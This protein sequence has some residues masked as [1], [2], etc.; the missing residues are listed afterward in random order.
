[1]GENKNTKLVRIQEHKKKFNI[2]GNILSP[3]PIIL[4]IY[5][6]GL[7]VIQYLFFYDWNVK[8]LRTAAIIEIAF[9][10]FN[11]LY[12]GTAKKKKTFETYLI[13]LTI[14]KTIVIALSILGSDLSKII[15]NKTGVANNDLDELSMLLAYI[16]NIGITFTSVIIFPYILLSYILN[17]TDFKTIS[18]LTSGYTRN[19]WFLFL[20]LVE[21]ALFYVIIFFINKYLNDLATKIWDAI[22][23]E[24]HSVSTTVYGMV[25]KVLYTMMRP[26]LL[27]GWL[28]AL[29]MLNKI[30]GGHVFNDKGPQIYIALKI[31]LLVSYVDMYNKYNVDANI[32]V[33][34][35][36]I[37]ISIIGASTFAQFI[38]I[39]VAMWR[40]AFIIDD[41]YVPH[42]IKV[43]P[44]INKTIKQL[45]E[46]KDSRLFNLFYER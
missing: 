18:K 24:N 43:H 9:T 14:A 13:F 6:V 32:D 33:L 11:W 29:I 22:I 21:V 7:F 27:V 1:M 3:L 23:V 19:T 40:N 2:L 15:D 25:T 37:M 10:G 31:S 4:T 36:I 30:R 26:V 28:P 39:F 8:E 35:T 12:L 42:M 20:V 44:K 5:I 38:L 16:G 34:F 17:W 46:N 45:R 41:V